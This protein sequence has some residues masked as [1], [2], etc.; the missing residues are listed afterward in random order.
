MEEALTPGSH[1]RRLLYKACAVLKLYWEDV[2]KK[3]KST[4]G[5]S[6]CY[7]LRLDEQ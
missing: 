5:Y 3:R 4:V 2:K 1:L 6:S 7:K